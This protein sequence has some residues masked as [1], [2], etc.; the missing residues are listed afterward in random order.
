VY[1]ASLLLFCLDKDEQRKLKQL[2]S[3]LSSLRT[4]KARVSPE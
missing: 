2:S 1:V 3:N 4:F